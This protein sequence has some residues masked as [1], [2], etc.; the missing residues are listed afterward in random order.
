MVSRTRKHRQRRRK[1]TLRVT[2]PQRGGGDFII[3]DI[4]KLDEATRDRIEEHL[5][6]CWPDTTPVKRA[7]DWAT[8]AKSPTRIDLMYKENDSG[9]IVFSR[10]IHHWP[11]EATP[12]LYIQET[13]VSPEERGKGH[14]KTSLE[15]M[16]THYPDFITTLRNKV[17]YQTIGDVGFSQRIETFHRMG[18]RLITEDKDGIPLYLKL[19]SGELVEV[20]G[21]A[22]GAEGAGG[23]GAG[24]GAGTTVANARAS[25]S[26]KYNVVDSAGKAHTIDVKDIEL[27]LS[28]HQIPKTVTTIDGKTYM[29]DKQIK[30]G[31]MVFAPKRA[32]S[33]S[34]GRS[35]ASSSKQTRSRS[36]PSPSRPQRSPKKI[37]I[38]WE[39]VKAVR[40][41]P[42]PVD[43]KDET[44]LSKIYCAQSMPL[45]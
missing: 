10:I 9:Q 25:K 30:T 11:E 35:T 1:S 14:Y 21:L 15:K 16:R 28:P 20:I 13:C 24:A 2:R 39:V 31:F 33:A 18:Y 36:A 23:A 27:C 22:N 29:V 8:D 19:K 7:Y 12:S 17:E 40:S 26:F 43:L 5:Q 42:L 41:E 4:T 6:I 38:P 37:E 34:R 3:E 32:A 45:R 44:T